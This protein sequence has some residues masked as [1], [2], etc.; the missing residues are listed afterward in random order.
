MKA[1]LLIACSLLGWS[2]SA[3]AAPITLE[4][5]LQRADQKS[6]SVKS[7]EMAAQAANESLTISRTSF[8]PTLKL[9]GA[10]T[11][12]D[13]PQRL[14]INRNAFETGVPPQDVSLTTGDRSVYTLGLYLQQPLYT[15]GAL[16]QTRRRAEFQAQAAQSD[17]AYQR[18]Q[19]AQQV[20][21]AFFEA[22][23]STLQVQALLK[24]TAAAREQA[25]VV[26]E[27]L[28]E[29]H[30]SREDLL[31]AQ[32]EISRA[33]AAWAR[34]ENR[35]EMA[36]AT[37]RKLISAAPE[38]SLEP[39]GPL[40]KAHLKAPLSE[41]LGLGL[42]Q[43]ADLK[44]L[45]ARVQQGSAEVGVAR[46]AFYPQVSL[47]GSYL[48]QQETAI[49]RADV[50][51]IGAQVEWSLF[52]WGRTSAEVRRAT[53]WAAQDQY[54]QEEASKNAQLEIEQY[55]HDMKDGEAQVRAAE[56]QVIT[57][58]YA[59]EKILDRFQEG[60]LK[61]VDVLL[62]EAALWDA[63]AAY[64]RSAADL[65][66]TQANLQRA[67]GVALEPWLESGPLYQPDFGA[68]EK[69]INQSAL[70]RPLATGFPNAVPQEIPAEPAA[71]PVVS[72]PAAVLPASAS[73]LPPAVVPASAPV[74][75]APP[76]VAPAPAPPVVAPAPPVVAPAPAP[77]VSEPL[78]ALPAL[79]PAPVHSAP[80]PVVV[81]P[82]LAAAAP[83]PF[84]PASAPLAVPLSPA[85]T[86]ADPEPKSPSVQQTRDS[87]GYVVQLGAFKSYANAKRIIQS[88]DKKF[89]GAPKPAILKEAGMFK[90]LAGPFSDKDT[91]LR[92][93]ADLGVKE[94]LVKVAH[95]P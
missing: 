1:N 19:T 76:V 62:A 93:A 42:Q 13:R 35:A 84:V 47:V 15:G 32:L 95:G 45:A 79:A 65:N 11:L 12:Y 33:E 29:G 87:R 91:A 24:G 60:Y 52:E 5:C 28:Q 38:E 81:R 94:Y 44:A 27:R 7:F 64:V 53:A 49:T 16:T 25:R 18:A 86:A 20:K 73:V 69:R 70:S 10:Y 21:K 46:S 78:P 17:T 82:I 41:L 6:S 74:A 77:V 88:L 55:W 43:R 48:R 72:A 83:V 22:L 54:R 90:V 59:L 26:Q 66:A 89:E 67:A 14:I 85:A 80:D 8:Y 51:T 39:S 68:I 56:T 30:A 23:A 2:A 50:W 40:A 71:A 9:K 31:A 4:T 57:R 58:E 37:L 61:R 36:L 75:P 63:D 92:A 34:G 3:F